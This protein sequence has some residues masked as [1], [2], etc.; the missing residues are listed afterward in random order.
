MQQ[1]VY[2]QSIAGLKQ[3]VFRTPHICVKEVLIPLPSP[4]ASIAQKLLNLQSTDEVLSSPQRKAELFWTPGRFCRV[5]VMF[6]LNVGF[7][8]WS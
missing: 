7:W 5:W 6:L 2:F 3:G 4:T 8:F 1:T